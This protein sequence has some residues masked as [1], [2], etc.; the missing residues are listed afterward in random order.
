M[1]KIRNPEEDQLSSAGSEDSWA[2]ELLNQDAL[3]VNHFRNEKTKPPNMDHEK[4]NIGPSE[5]MQS[6][7]KIVKSDML[8]FNKTKA[9]LADTR[10]QTEGEGGLLLDDILAGRSTKVF[11]GIETKDLDENRVQFI[12]KVIINDSNDENQ[13]YG[14]IQKL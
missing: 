3:V 14:D 12:P 1:N 4:E 11:Q 13:D 6:V 8:L 10:N 9:S 7:G 2:N 5:T